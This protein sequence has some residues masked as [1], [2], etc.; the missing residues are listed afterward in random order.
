[1]RQIY[2]THSRNDEP[3]ARA[4]EAALEMAG[5]TVWRHTRTQ[6]GGW[7]IATAKSHLAEADDVIAIWSKDSIE[8]QDVLDAAH[9]GLANGRLTSVLAEYVQPPMGMGK[10]K[11]IDMTDWQGEQTEA[12]S[13]RLRALFP[14][15]VAAPARA[16][17]GADLPIWPFALTA[18][19][20]IAAIGAAVS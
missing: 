5:H 10:A 15:A 8:N 11:I 2:I 9:S 18:A 19:T 6:L 20:C 4:L 12:A 14:G 3:T 1:M 16:G 17:F 13:L 7:R